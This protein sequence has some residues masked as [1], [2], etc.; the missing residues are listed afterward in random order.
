[1]SGE[2]PGLIFFV[3]IMYFS[4]AYLRA[5][6]STQTQMHKALLLL[7]FVSCSSLLTAQD[8]SIKLTFNHQALSVRDIDKSVAFYKNVL[9]L[10]E[11]EN[12]TKVAGRRWFSLGEGLELH[13]ISMPEEKIVVSKSVH[14][15]LTTPTFDALVKMLDGKIIAYSDFPGAPKKITLR[16]DGVRQI[17]FQDPDGYWIEVNSVAAK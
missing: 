17:F 16:A 4:N 5:Y 3:G 2:S 7:F 11:I 6:N 13:L 15:A 14:L 9:Q 12:R 8:T 1:M 10:T